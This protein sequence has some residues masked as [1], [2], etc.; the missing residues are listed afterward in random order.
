VQC[1]T[2]RAG[3]NQ[4]VHWF[5]GIKGLDIQQ[6]V[7]VGSPKSTLRDVK[8]RLVTYHQEHVNHKM[9]LEM[10]YALQSESCY[11]TIHVA[12]FNQ[13]HGSPLGNIYS[14]GHVIRKMRVESS[15]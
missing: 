14:V 3:A 12:L 5:L 4:H 15:R 2:L 1:F 8:N 13:K 11:H 10:P 7:W 9:E 6:G